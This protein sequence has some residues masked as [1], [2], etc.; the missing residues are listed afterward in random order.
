MLLQ[1]WYGQ[2]NDLTDLVRGNLTSLQHLTLDALI[3]IDVHVK[4]MQRDIL[5]IPLLLSAASLS[6]LPFAPPTPSAF[7]LDIVANCGR[8]GEQG[9]PGMDFQ[10]LEENLQSQS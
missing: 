9:T 7:C 6:A 4:M 5:F 2:L 10:N 1:K 8:G 3:A